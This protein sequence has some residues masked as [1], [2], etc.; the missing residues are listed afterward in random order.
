M[1]HQQCLSCHTAG[2]TYVVTLQAMRCCFCGAVQ[3]TSPEPAP[4]LDSP[5]ELRALTVEETGQ[6][7]R[8]DPRR[9]P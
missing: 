5:H 6:P 1:S 3:D 8:H 7:F 2:M 9:T 4:G